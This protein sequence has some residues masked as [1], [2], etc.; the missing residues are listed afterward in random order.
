MQL[1]V[2]QRIDRGFGALE[3]LN[4]GFGYSIAPK[5]ATKSKSESAGSR[6]QEHRAIRHHPQLLAVLDHCGRRS[7]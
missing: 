2:V 6:L 7:R 3:S 5:L 4:E 1:L